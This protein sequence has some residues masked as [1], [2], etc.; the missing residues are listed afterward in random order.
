[1]GHLAG[2]RLGSS[3]EATLRE[4]AAGAGL[5]A[6]LWWQVHRDEGDLRS[7]IDPAQAGP[8]ITPGRHSTI[9]VWTESELCALHALGRIVQRR[10]ARLSEAA[11]RPWRARLEAARAWHVEHTQPDNGTNR[12]WAVAVFAT[13]GSA[14]SQLYAETL[15]HNAL[16]SGHQNQS[17][18]GLE[19]LCAAI[20]HDAAAQ[21][22]AGA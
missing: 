16:V 2:S 5:E 17:A 13:V 19:P 9:E 6:W 3:G 11:L 21:L 7:L 12:P 4:G 22:E 1:M 10:S 20:L 15:L 18:G 14:E 8:L